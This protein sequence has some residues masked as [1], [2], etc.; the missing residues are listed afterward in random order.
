M[1]SETKKA[2]TALAIKA[3]NLLWQGKK[4]SNLRMLESKSRA[5]TNLATPLQCI[6]CILYLLW[7]L[8][9]WQMNEKIRFC[10]S[11]AVSLSSQDGLMKSFPPATTAKLPKGNNWQLADGWNLHFSIWPVEISLLGH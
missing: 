8:E 9:L 5:L 1:Y 7:F 4:D 2:L 10:A 3:F 6:N 11:V